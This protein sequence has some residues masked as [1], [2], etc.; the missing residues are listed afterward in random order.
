[1]LQTPDYAR[2]VTEGS[3]AWKTAED[4][5]RFA[6]LRLERQRP[7]AERPKPLKIWAVIPE[8]VLRQEVGGRACMRAQLEHL[9]DLA[10]NNPHVTLQVLPFSAGAHAGMDGPFMLMSFPTGRDLVCIESLR[11]DLHLN[12][13]DTV[14]LYKTISDLL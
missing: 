8:G 13:P 7:I 11:A 3:R 12:D 10:R 5:D 14:E 1:M 9:I 2:A 4:I 6:A